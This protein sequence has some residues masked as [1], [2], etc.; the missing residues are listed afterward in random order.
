MYCLPQVR[1]LFFCLFVLFIYL[2]FGCLFLK[3]R[4][5]SLHPRI[6]NIPACR[7]DVT[8][9][10]DLQPLHGHTRP[11][12]RG[13]KLNKNNILKIGQRS[14]SEERQWPFFLY[15]RCVFHSWMWQVFVHF[16]I[17]FIEHDMNRIHSMKYLSW[18]HEPILF[19]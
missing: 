13:G 6:H 5:A 9:V 11:R 19:F 8:S 15:G 1:D 14:Q 16:Q 4:W 2:F 12:G 18:P 3:R 7:V 17:L 10:C